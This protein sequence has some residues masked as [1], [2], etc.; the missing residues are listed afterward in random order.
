MK[1]STATRAIDAL[2]NLVAASLAARPALVEWLLST[3]QK[4]PYE[5]LTGYMLRW[6]LLPPAA[7]RG[8]AEFWRVRNQLRRLRKNARLHLLLRGDRESHHHNHPWEFRTLVL[9]GWYVN[10]V[11]LPDG[12]TKCKVI[13]AGQSYRMGVGEFHRI[14][15]VSPG[16]ALTLVFYATK[17]TGRWWGF[18]VDGEV[19]HWRTYLGLG[20]PG[21]TPE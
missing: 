21:E 20:T 12:T 7:K 16:G 6:W 9:R 2:W 13:Y 1:T 8:S 3:G 4:T 10:E 15:A 11:T 19:I 17:R 14:A 18:L 5:H